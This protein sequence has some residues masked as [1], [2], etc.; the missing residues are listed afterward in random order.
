MKYGELKLGQVEAIVNKLGGH[1]GAMKFLR[2]E[3]VIS[4]SVLNWREE[5]GVIYFDVVSDG[6]TGPEWIKRLKEQGINV[7]DWAR[8]VLN[9]KDFKPTKSG[10]IHKIGVLKGELF[11]DGDRTNEKIRKEAVKR[12]MI[13]PE[14]EIG[15]LIREKFTDKDINDMGLSWI[16]TMHDPIKD[17][18]GGPDLLYAS[19]HGGGSWLDASYGD[20]D[21]RWD[22]EGG[23][24][25]VVSQV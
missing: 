8:D 25:F 12:K 20:P 9:S 15:C 2:G 19:R 3:L 4:E 16:T 10:T 17:S 13:L 1:E 23:F 11:S 6:T 14:A 24:A 5:D 18:D 22:R 21:V 7:S